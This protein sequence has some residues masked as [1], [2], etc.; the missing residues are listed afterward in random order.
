MTSRNYW[1]LRTGLRKKQN[2]LVSLW[3]RKKK[4]RESKREEVEE[5][6][7]GQKRTGNAVDLMRQQAEKYY[8]R[9]YAQAKKEASL[10]VESFHV[11]IET[12]LLTEAELDP[13]AE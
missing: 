2:L 6:L 4:R 10:E 11:A 13:E 5:I 12:Q 7:A 8:E 3:R 1:H 9:G